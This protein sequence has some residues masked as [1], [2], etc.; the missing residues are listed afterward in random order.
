MLSE[1][2]AL[3]QTQE[4]A[5]DLEG[6]EAAVEELKEEYRDFVECAE[7]EKSSG[8]LPGSGEKATVLTY[9]YTA[10]QMIGLLETMGD[11]VFSSQ[12]FL[13]YFDYLASR[14]ETSLPIPWKMDG[15]RCLRRCVRA[16]PEILQFPTISPTARS[17]FCRWT[18]P[19]R[20]TASAYRCMPRWIWGLESGVLTADIS[21]E[22]GV[23]RI[24]MSLRS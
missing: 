2:D 18:R 8:K 7:G 10:D 21:M 22:D 6:M 5:F 3:F 16:I 13:S 15:M 23:D 1:L 17:R 14:L 9:V 11:T 19:L 12:G 20:L 24:G 4:P